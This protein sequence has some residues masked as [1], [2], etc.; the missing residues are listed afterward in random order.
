MH[1]IMELC[2]SDCYAGEA[3]VRTTGKTKTDVEAK[4]HNDGNNAKFWGRQNKMNVE[5]DKYMHVNRNTA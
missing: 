1:L 2:D 5:Y 4:L 3:T